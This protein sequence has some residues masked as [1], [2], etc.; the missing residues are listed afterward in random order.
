M[1]EPSEEAI[2][3]FE[4]QRRLTK[5]RREPFPQRRGVLS[6]RQSLASRAFPDVAWE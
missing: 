1:R 5:E 3:D 4:A 6:A 2:V